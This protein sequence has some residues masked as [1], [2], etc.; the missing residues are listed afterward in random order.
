MK[1]FFGMKW[2]NSCSYIVLEAPSERMTSASQREKCWQSPKNAATGGGGGGGRY[3]SNTLPV[4]N[5]INRALLSAFWWE[6]R[7]EKETD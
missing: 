6:G 7:D 3:C 5:N 1:R 2:M 4:S